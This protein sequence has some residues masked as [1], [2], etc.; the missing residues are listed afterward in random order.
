[1]VHPHD[2]ALMAHIEAGFWARGERDA[3]AYAKA[4]A[5]HDGIIWDTRRRPPAPDPAVD[6]HARSTSSTPRPRVSSSSSAGA[7]SNGQ[8]VSAELNPWAL[9]LGND[10]PT[11]ERLGSY[12]RRYYVPEKNTEPLWAA[13]RDG[14]ID[15][16]STDHA[17]HLREEKEPGWTDGWKAHTGTPST[18]FYVPLFLDAASRG[19]ISVE[20]VVDLVATAP[21]A[22]FGLAGKGRLEVGRDADI[23]IVDLDAEFEI[24][25]E[26]VLS[27]IGC[28]PYCRPARA[29]RDRD[30]PR[31]RPGGLRRWRGRREPGLGPPGSTI[32]VERIAKAAT[33]A[34]HRAKE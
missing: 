10:W 14:T 5:A 4:Y 13:L 31:P 27:K 28:S 16:V 32:P 3:R 23:A 9:F 7:K 24:R 6:R 19:L 20:R 30:H 17:P 15:L 21:A 11:I 2:Q 25:D 33:Q 12:A 29:R 22:R 8:D 34:A 26:I 18:Q 1:M